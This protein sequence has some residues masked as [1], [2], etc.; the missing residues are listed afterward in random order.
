MV[1]KIEH[2]IETYSLTTFSFVDSDT[3]S[4]LEEAKKSNKH[5]NFS[6]RYNFNKNGQYIFSFTKKE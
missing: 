5:I 4:K 6:S 1:A 2:I 3:F